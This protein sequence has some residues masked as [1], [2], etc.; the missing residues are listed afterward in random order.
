MPLSKKQLAIYALIVLV[1]QLSIG[2]IIYLIFNKWDTRGQFGDMFGFVNALFSGL[3]FTAVILTL[4]YQ[5]KEIRHTQEQIELQN[6]LTTIQSFENTFFNLLDLHNNLITTLK[7]QT[8][9]G[10]YIEGRNVFNY[11]CKMLDNKLTPTIMYPT[12]TT[13]YLSVYSDVYADVCLSTTSDIGYYFRNLY[14]IIKFIKEYPSDSIIKTKYTSIVRAQFSREE[15]KL[16]MY[17]CLNVIGREKFKGLVEEYSLLENMDT[18]QIPD[19]V[20]SLYKPIAFD[21]KYKEP[22]P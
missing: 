16:L 7:V 9:N 22:P 1:I 17:N 20:R 11:L 2:F 5:Q 13:D 12:M 6:M 21:S 3:A 4:Y 14:H 10:E 18:R 8:R 19:T 15:Y